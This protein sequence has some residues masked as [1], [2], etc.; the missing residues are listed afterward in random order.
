MK[1]DKLK[2]DDIQ[3]EKVV[4]ELK[5]RLKY[6]DELNLNLIQRNRE[7]KA[8]LRLQL[9]LKSELTEKELLLTVGLESLLLLKKHR[10]N[11]IDR[12]SVV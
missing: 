10:Y 3:L 1:M 4:S 2:K 6:K 7:L 8:K 12:K 9:S 11:H 5:E